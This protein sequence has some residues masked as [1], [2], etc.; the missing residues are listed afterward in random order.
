MPQKIPHDRSEFLQLSCKRYRHFVED[1][2]RLQLEQDGNDV[3]TDLFQGEKSEVITSE[4]FVRSNGIV[5]GQEEVDFF[6]SKFF[7]DINAYW[8]KVDGTAFLKN[9]VLVKFEGPPSSLLRAERIVLNVLSRLCGIATVTKKMSEKMPENIFLA[10]TRKTLWGALDKKAVTLGGGLS[11]RLGLFDAVLVKENHLLAFQKNAAA[12]MQYILRS[13][14][15][16]ALGAFWE[17]EVET[18]TQLHEVLDM[19][20]S[21]SGA[22]VPGV[23][24]LDNFSPSQTRNALVSIATEDWNRKNIFF[25]VSGGIT[26][27]NFLAFAIPGVNVISSGFLTHTASPIDMSLRIV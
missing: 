20:A 14:H 17:I 16:N 18:E 2:F 11:H 13:M 27:E 15:S 7:G 9:T 5:A 23:V 22:T 3:T 1:F 19:L 26:Q 24:M 6:L 4:I 8:N 25:E 12:A 10:A 21:V